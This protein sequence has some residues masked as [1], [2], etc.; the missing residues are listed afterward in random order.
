M[1]TYAIGDVQGCFESLLKLVDEI[2]FDPTKDE[3]W[4]AG[5][6][7]NRGPGSLPALRFAYEHRASVRMVLGNHDLH[8]LGRVA[9][10]RRAGRRDTLDE[11]F[12]AEDRDVLVEWLRR[13]PL[14]LADRG[15]LMVHAGVLPSWTLQDVLARSREVEQV[16]GSDE[17]V[18][19]LTSMWSKGKR[20]KRF[21]RH[22]ETMSVLTLLRILDPDMKPAY[23]F[24][25]A[26]E[27]APP[28]YRAW[29]AAPGRKTAEDVI[30]FGHWAA[31]GH[32]LRQRVIALDS[33]CVW[34]NTLTAVRL[35][36]RAVF[37]VDNAERH[38]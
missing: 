37:Q 13:Q 18:R 22:H 7:I 4:F 25:R 34:G 38:R 11:L 3:L 31:L 35:E 5:D 6:L 1:A 23:E 17:W 9:G 33:G 21:A 20:E 32:H 12:A 14:A 10:V 29:F 26:P 27:D 24:K 2:A 19:L 15:V 30:V 16:L 28:G 36:D 8:F